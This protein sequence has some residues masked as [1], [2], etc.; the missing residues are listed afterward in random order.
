VLLAQAAVAFHPGLHLRQGDRIRDRTR[1]RIGRQRRLRKQ[2][3]GDGGERAK[4]EDDGSS[5]NDRPSEAAHALRKR[6]ALVTTDTELK[7]I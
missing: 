6:K 4:R 2:E 5:M 3:G 1:A 7:L